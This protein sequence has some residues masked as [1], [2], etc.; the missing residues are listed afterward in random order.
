MKARL[1]KYMYITIAAAS[2]CL[3]CLV[4]LKITQQWRRTN[5]DT[6][7][8]ITS[9]SRK[10]GVSEKGIIR[11]V[12]STFSKTTVHF[13]KFPNEKWLRVHQTHSKG[14]WACL[15]NLS[16]A[17]HKRDI[18]K[19]CRPKSDVTLCDIWSGSAL[20]ALSPEISTKHNNKNQSNTP[21]IGKGPDPRDKAEE[22]A[23]HKWV[24]PTSLQGFKY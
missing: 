18:G 24:K 7:S 16:L 6:D 19:Q 5:T 23:W 1:Y 20:F 3:G 21:Y 4:A 22:S 13:W 2:L 17:S 11:G 10:R 14:L 15:T 9:L 8:L 12:K